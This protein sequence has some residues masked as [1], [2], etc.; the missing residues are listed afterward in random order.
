MPLW[1]LFL[2]VFVIQLA[3]EMLEQFKHHLLLIGAG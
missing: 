1:Y 2:I 3:V